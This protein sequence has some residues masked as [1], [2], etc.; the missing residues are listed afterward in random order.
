V[1]R[2]KLRAGWLSITGIFTLANLRKSVDV[3]IS[4][5]N[6]GRNRHQVDHAVGDHLSSF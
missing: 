1:I 5:L 4:I 2:H 3:L 6:Q